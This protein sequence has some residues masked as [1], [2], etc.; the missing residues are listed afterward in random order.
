MSSPVDQLTGTGAE[1]RPAGALTDLN[2]ALAPYSGPWNLK[3]AAHLLRRAGFGGSPADV[4]SVAAAGMSTS[5]ERLIHFGPD[6]LPTQ[7]D[8]DITYDFSPTA[9]PKQRQR[10]FS[11]PCA[12][13]QRVLDPGH[14]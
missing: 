1:F 6:S 11:W 3:L 13:H 12:L 5:V 10:A 14:G 2:Q 9:D 4:G 7:P 8:G